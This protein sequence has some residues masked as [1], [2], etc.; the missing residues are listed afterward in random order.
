[1]NDEMKKAGIWRAPTPTVPATTLTAQMEAERAAKEYAQY[2]YDRVAGMKNTTMDNA[3]ISPYMIGN[4]SGTGISF[5]PGYSASYQDSRTGDKD[6]G[7]FQITKV[8]NGF[9]VKHAQGNGRAY[10]THIATTLDELRDLIAT[11]LVANQLDK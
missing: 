11:V 4:T 3:V 2:Q 1:M 5:P 8:G 9:V 6:L 7:T 10:D